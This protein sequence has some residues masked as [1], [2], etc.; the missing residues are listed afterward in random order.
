MCK[1]LFKL[2]LCLSLVFMATAN[3]AWAQAS[4]KVSGTVVDAQGPVIGAA[5]MEKGTGNGVVTDIDGKYEIK[6]PSNATIVVSCIGYLTQE[7]AVGN[8]SVIN[9]TLEEDNQ[10][11]EETVVVG[12]GTQ[13]K[14]NL[15]GAISTV[16]V[17]KLTESRPI[18]NIGNA[19]AG[20]AAG[21]SVTAGSS[22]PGS[23]NQKIIIRGVGT[24]NTAT[25]LIIIDGVQA[26][27][28]SVNPQDVESMTV[29]KDAASS[30]IYG[31]RAAN[32][33]ILITT[34]K[35]KSGTVK[36]DYN[37]YASI[38]SIR[39]PKSL[40]PVSDYADYMEY[41][42]EGYT[43]QG[44][45]A[46]FSQAKIDEWRNATASGADPLMYPNQNYL[47]ATFHT[48]VAQNHVLSVTGGTD[49]IRIYSS[50]GYLNNPGVMDRSGEARYTG[51]VNVEADATKWLTV[52]TNVNGYVSKL[53]MG[54]NPDISN[55]ATTPGMTFKFP[56]GRFG[57]VENSEDDPQASANNPIRARYT[58]DGSDKANNISARFYGSIKP[59]KGFSVTGSY[60]YQFYDSQRNTV[61]VFQNL[62]SY[63]TDSIVTSGI[64]KSS[65]TNTDSKNIRKYGD[66][67]AKYENSWVDNKLD[68]SIMA[69][70]STESYTSSSFSATRY[71]LIDMSLQALNAATGDMSCS[72]SSS[73]WAMTSYFGR[74]NLGWDGRYLLEGNFR[75]DASSRFLEGNR[76]GYFPSGSFAW[77]MSEE[78]WMKGSGVDNLKFRISYGGLGNN[79]VGNYEAQSLY[80]TQNYV[81]GNAVAVGMA[82]TALANANLTWETTYVA[83]FGIDFGFLKNRLTG[84]VDLFNKYTDGILISLPAPAVHG[85]TS[86]P[87]QNA[88]EVRNRGVE[89]TLG[90]QDT[91]GD[92]YYSVSGNFTYVK[93]KV[94]KFKG[95]E[96]SLSG[97]NYIREGYSINSQYLLRYDRIIQTAEDMKIVEDMLAANPNAFNAFGK[98]KYGDLLYKDINGDG[99]INNDDKEVVSDGPNP[100]FYFGLNFA[101]GWKGIDF[102]ML[103]Q[104]VA[105]AKQFWQAI[106][107]NLPI[108]YYGNQLNKQ[109][110]EGAWREGRTDATYPR[111]TTKEYTQNTQASDFYLEN[112][113]YLKIRNIQLGYTLPQK[114]TSKIQLE[115]VRFYVSLENFFT[116][117]QFRGF[118]PEVSGY[119]YPTLKQALFG[120][121]I[122]F[123]GKSNK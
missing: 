68:F 50:F 84:T 40:T 82:Q 106:G 90:W 107:Q 15:S 88:A 52:G 66:V 108:V 12:F 9:V 61:P 100:K 13:K 60:T 47:D 96:Y 39:Y 57:G 48:G 105:G 119:A 67:I 8:K 97:A 58:T 11:L 87:T 30:A 104:G 46:K 37:G 6:V 31:S 114:W 35:G 45:A 74:L 29:L 1:K 14:V 72:G 123:G 113:A 4:M 28:N 86:I 25:P 101:C 76:W 85:T 53:D 44:Q 64:G 79:S 23:D 115:R 32:G 36:V 10:M 22:A 122:T 103:L 118:D 99:L 19:L 77:R 59:F 78:R 112:L 54:A 91:K 120:I 110:A 34:K 116:F 117:T 93:N 111:L 73:S 71:D 51:R 92:F 38:E 83:N 27:M 7:I 49:K 33:V 16:N 81:L 56:D 41:L 80:N 5:I 95:D 24:L 109:I 42:N 62:Y 43:N 121:N 102:S 3:V 26:S 63:Q 98:P 94:M 21:V 69:G 89:L 18:T 17:D 2:V 55:I 65:A 70:G 20:T 75:A